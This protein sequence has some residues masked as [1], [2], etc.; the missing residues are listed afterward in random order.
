VGFWLASWGSLQGHSSHTLYWPCWV[1]RPTSEGIGRVWGYKADG[2]G[3]REKG[4]GLREGG[5]EGNGI[6]K[7]TMH[8]LNILLHPA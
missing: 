1:K 5:R 4:K 3:I 2:H 8:D 6:N 7:Q